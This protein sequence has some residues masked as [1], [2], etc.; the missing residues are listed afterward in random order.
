MRILQLCR[1]FPYPLKDGESV[2]ITA[3]SKALNN[4]GCELTLLSMN[5]SKHFTDISQLP[6][7]YNHYKAIHVAE[8]NNSLNPIKAFFN[9]FSSESYHV[10]RFISKEFEAKLIEIL[11]K[12]TFDIIQLESLFMTPYMDVIRKHSKAVIAMRSHNIEFEIWERITSN[13]ESKIKKWYLNHLTEKLKNYELR[14]LNGYDYLIA[15]SD[16]DLKKFKKLGYKN[17]AMSCP[18]SLNLEKYVPKH[19][20]V[21]NN[22]CF[23]GSLDWIPNLEGLDWFLTN[24]WDDLVNRNPKIEL[25]IAGRNTPKHMTENTK[26][27]VKIYGEIPN[28][29]EFINDYSVMIVPILSGSGVR[30]KILE[31][32]ALGKTV[33]TT[34]LGAEGIEAVDGQHL[35]IADTPEQ[36]VAQIE[37]ALGS[38]SLRASI[39]EEATEF[40][41]KYDHRENAKKL[42]ATYKQLMEKP[43]HSSVHA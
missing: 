21:S 18:V 39:S 19:K 34:T 13:T 32:L 14:H 9:L 15:V 31:G 23:I 10:V 17:G 6:A 43:Y 25:H 8:V 27:G 36:F 40:I 4:E 5:T 38:H 7:D 33:V 41:K 42:I 3:L 28:A 37:K 26:N 12:N 16:R 11:S 30:V 35:L 22:L 2:N 1:K 29:I 20:D 24:V